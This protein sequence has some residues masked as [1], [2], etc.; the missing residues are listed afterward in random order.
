MKKYL[1][2]IKDLHLYIG[3][4]ISPIIILFALSALVLNHNFID[5]EE[6]W[7]KW[8]FSVNN[9]VD[10]SFEFTVPDNNISEIDFAKD[11]LNQINISGEIANVFKDSNQ[12]YIPVTKPGHRISIKADLISGIAYIHSEQVNLWKR[13]IWLHKKPGPHNAHISGNWIYTKIWRSM[14]DLFVICL[15]FTSITG[16][17]LWYYFKNERKNGLIALVIGFISIVSLIIGLTL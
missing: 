5:W 11:I 4:F 6:D 15:L 1:Q 16:I 14:T 7:Q 9:Q 13:L 12:V 8:M 3:L 2:I 10:T 17:T